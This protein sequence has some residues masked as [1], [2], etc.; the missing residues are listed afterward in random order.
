MIIRQYDR[1]SLY[2]RVVARRRDA[3]GGWARDRRLREREAEVAAVVVDVTHETPVSRYNPFPAS[4]YPQRMPSRR[5]L[6]L[7]SSPRLEIGR[8][9]SAGSVR[10]AAAAAI[11]SGGVQPCGHAADD[12]DDDD[13]SSSSSCTGPRSTAA[14]RRRRRARVRQTS[15]TPRRGQL[16]GASQKTAERQRRPGLSG[17]CIR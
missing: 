6:L 14:R 17:R 1:V 8:R 12:D 11:V 15:V 13:S 10:A 5:G 3:A 7:R 2:D 9:R 4:D 16:A